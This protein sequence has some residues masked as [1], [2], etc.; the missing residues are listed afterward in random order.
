MIKTMIDKKTIKNSLKENYYGIK[1]DI[2][3]KRDIKRI[4]FDIGTLIIT[5][6]TL[7][8]F[9]ISKLIYERIERQINKL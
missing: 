3:G 8:I 2:Q 4:M 9:I 6:T 7:P 5:L 1:I